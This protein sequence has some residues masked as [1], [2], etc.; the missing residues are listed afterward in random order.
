M[1]VKETTPQ[2]H[3]SVGSASS[4][5]WRAGR[6]DCQCSL[7]GTGSDPVN[8]SRHQHA[9]LPSSVNRNE[10]KWAVDQYLNRSSC[11]VIFREVS[12]FCYLQLCDAGGDSVVEIALQ[13][14]HSGLQLHLFLLHVGQPLFSHLSLS[15]LL[16]R[17]C[18]SKEHLSIL[19]S[20]PTVMCSAAGSCRTQCHLWLLNDSPFYLR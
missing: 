17:L 11:Y 2:L 3:S 5:V 20:P 12:C 1:H 9:S 13:P 4:A 7:F 18:L 15:L 8:L 10:D 19:S 14:Y 16:S 6:S